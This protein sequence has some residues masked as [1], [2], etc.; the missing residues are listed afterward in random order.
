MCLITRGENPSKQT[1]TKSNSLKD[2]GKW[3]PFFSLLNSESWWR[4]CVDGSVL[5]LETL[6]PLGCSISHLFASCR[7]EHAGHPASLLLRWDLQI[8]SRQFITRCKWCRHVSSWERRRYLYANWWAGVVELL[9]FFYPPGRFYG[10]V[11]ISELIFAPFPTV[12]SSLQGIW[13]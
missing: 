13:Q 10:F 3:F 2:D 11:S 1:E 12:S 6:P 5:G 4:R 7:A 9:L 8:H